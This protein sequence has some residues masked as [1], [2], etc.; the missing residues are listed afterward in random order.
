MKAEQLWAQKLAD[1]GSTLPRGKAFRA[2]VKPTAVKT[3]KKAAAPKAVAKVEAPV[4][5]AKPAAPAATGLSDAQIAAM[6]EL[7]SGDWVAAANIT[8]R[9][10]T[11]N[12]LV[13]KG[14]VVSREQDGETEY[15]AA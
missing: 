7:T 4:E 2:S 3:A 12:A 8:A 5:E 11:L 1:Q 14:L 9:K 6:A 10:Q 15:K 13:K